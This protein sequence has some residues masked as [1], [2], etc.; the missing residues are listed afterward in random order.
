[1]TM[2]TKPKKTKTFNHQLFGRLGSKENDIQYIIDYLPTNINSVI[3]VFGGGFSLIRKVYSDNLDEYKL[4][5]NDLDNLLYKVYC[6]YNEYSKLAIELNE[7]VR[8]EQLNKVLTKDTIRKID[9]NKEYDKD[10]ISFWKGEKVIRGSIIKVIKNPIN[11]TNFINIMK[12]ISFTNDDYK[13]CIDKHKHNDKAFLFLDPPY[14]FSNNK[15]YTPTNIDND[16]TYIIVYVLEL[17]KDK[18]TKCKIMMIINDLELLRYLFKDY[19]KSEYNK[20]Y[21]LSKN[22]MKHLIITNY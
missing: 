11:H 16:M 18:K 3:E 21:Q 19:I 14:L 2:T 10:F 13:V 22:K 9:E 4:Y 5:V 6:N 8:L 20:V 7:F 12:K 17:L 15:S 1:M